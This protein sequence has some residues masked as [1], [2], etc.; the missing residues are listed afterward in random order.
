MVLKALVFAG[1]LL[2]LAG[3]AAHNE[4]QESPV[5]AFNQADWHAKQGSKL[6]LAV[7]GTGYTLKPVN[8]GWLI[9]IREQGTFHPQRPE[10]L[11]PSALGSI[12]QLTRHLAADPDVA[13]M[14][15]GVATGN[16][17]LKSSEQVCHERA[18]SIASIFR[19]NQVPGHKLRLH[20]IS[21]APELDKTL[22]AALLV[23]PEQTLHARMAHYQANTVA[24]LGTSPRD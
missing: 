6:R 7:E 20:G 21:Q 13:V 4:V 17:K 8:D 5:Q 11:L 12:G 18:G 22:G 1:G 23:V 16:Y 9:S 2:L 3:C 10:M 24:M 15:V 14:V 19:L